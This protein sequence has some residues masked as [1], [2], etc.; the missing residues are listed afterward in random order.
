[1]LRSSLGSTDELTD[2]VSDRPCYSG[3]AVSAIA[4]GEAPP[5]LA[6]LQPDLPWQL[7]GLQ[8]L[9]Q[10]L[11]GRRSLRQVQRDTARQ[12]AQLI[13]HDRLWV[14]EPDVEGDPM[15]VYSCAGDTAFNL[16]PEP[17]QR[18]YQRMADDMT[19]PGPAQATAAEAQDGRQ[20]LGFPIV[21]ARYLMSVIVVACDGSDA[22]EIARITRLID[23]V[24]HQT[25]I[26]C[27]NARLAEAMSQMIIEV[28]VSMATAVESR[29][30]YTGGHVQRVTQ[31]AL[32]LG[33]KLGLDR[34]SMSILH[35][36]GL[37]HDI[38]KVAVPDAI[39]RKPGKLTREEFEVIKTHTVVGHQIVS[40]I[41]HLACVHGIVRSHHERYDGGGYPDG[42]P[43]EAVPLLARIVAIADTFDA[44]TSDRS[45]RQGMPHET[46]IAEIDRN[47]GTQFDPDLA[48]QFANMPLSELAMIARHEHR[49]FSLKEMPY[50]LDLVDLLDLKLPALAA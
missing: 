50:S 42:L 8:G 31:Y 20:Y 7:A 47:A 28:V 12:I 45:Y 49:G 48:I 5:T 4:D 30:P 6:S 39:L 3:G 21:S 15:R 35:I 11:A 16:L 26:A 25:G 14:I 44:M 23:A 40:Q 10:Q 18:L 19:R 33:S 17:A 41:P 1:M 24:L 37:L 13:G 9:E 22:P 46:A 32:L 2:G 27:E 36:G 34:E 29:D 38:G 43:G